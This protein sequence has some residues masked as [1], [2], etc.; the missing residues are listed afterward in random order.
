MNNAVNYKGL[1]LAKNSEAYFLWDLKEFKKLDAHLKELDRKA[2]E[3]QDRY[4]S[5]E[6]STPLLD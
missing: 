4:S 3:L 1:W 2:K 6:P 5:W